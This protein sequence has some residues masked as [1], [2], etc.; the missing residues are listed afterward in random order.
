MSCCTFSV[1]L[2]SPC[3]I[4]KSGFEV[5]KWGLF[6]KKMHCTFAEAIPMKQHFLTSSVGPSLC[7]GGN[8]RTWR[9][10]WSGWW[11]WLTWQTVTQSNGRRW[12]FSEIRKTFVSFS[13]LIF[14]STL[15]IPFTYWRLG[16]HLPNAKTGKRTPDDKI[17]QCCSSHHLNKAN[18]FICS[19]SSPN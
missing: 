10:R 1:P 4:C 19:C 11:L 5:W 12:E 6:K 13:I 18:L 2:N 8:Q 17:A 7:P 14:I 3:K 15:L 9:S 16:D